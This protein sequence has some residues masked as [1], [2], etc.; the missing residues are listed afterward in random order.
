MKRI[1]LGALDYGLSFSVDR[2]LRDL[3]RE[4][5]LSAVGSIVVTDLWSRE[6]LPLRETADEVGDR[7]LFGLTVT[8]SGDRAQPLSERMAKTYGNAMPTRSYLERRAFLRLLPDEILL[9]EIGAQIREYVARMDREPEFVAVREGLFDRTAIAKHVMQAIN[10]AELSSTP[11]LV[12]GLPPGLQAARVRKM[13]EAAG[14]KVLPWG[15]PLPETNDT[16]KLHKLLRYHFDGLPDMTFVAG[17]P[18]AADDR[19]RRDE[20]REKISVRECHREVLSS[21]RFFRTLD[22]KNVFLN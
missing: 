19:L 14:L 9:E 20:S 15:P 13:A 7:A 11:Y 21:G 18:G 4:G 1:T 12:T 8:L 2:T 16:E 6:F 3:L 5:R 10:D 22:E 17:V